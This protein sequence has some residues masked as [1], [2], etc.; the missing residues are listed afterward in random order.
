VRLPTGSAKA[1]IGGFVYRGSKMAGLC[2]RYFYG[3]HSG[4]V[5]SLKV[6][7]GKATDVRTHAELATGNL[8][9]FGQDTTGELYIANTGGQVFRIE[10]AP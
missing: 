5:Y 2:G 7:G 10:Q 6:E 9:S 4:A 1:V 3:A 8:S